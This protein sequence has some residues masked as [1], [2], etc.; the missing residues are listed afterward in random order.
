MSAT[1][2]HIE[3]FR[4]VMTSGSVTEAAAMLHTSQPTVSRELARFEQLTQLKLF[5]RVRGRLR[6][7]AQALSLFE[8]VQRAY[9]GLGRILNAAASLREFEHG[10]LSIACLPVFSQSLLPRAC[11]RFFA[12]FPK[13]SM[14]ITPQESPLLEEWLSAQR[15]DLGL[16]EA[17]TAPPG[18]E[19][20]PLMVV[21]EVCVLPVGHPLLEKHTLEPKDFDSQP[22]VSL[23]NLDSYRQQIDEI[24]LQAQVERQMVLDTHSAASV[25]AMVREHVGLAIVNPLTALEFVGQGLE[26]RQFTASIPFT[27]SLVKPLYRPASPLV[28]LFED[29]LREQAALVD[30]R[31]AAIDKRHSSA[32]SPHLKKGADLSDARPS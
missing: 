1:L 17:A 4:A 16:T 29:A 3:V 6:P 11:Q 23:S 30:V 7:T 28:S 2:R 22:F 19:L 9:F 32:Q 18:T 31:L 8:E 5:D 20:V 26:I 25:C 24:F 13:A 10:Q 27:V 14:S 15:Y 21:D 12:Q